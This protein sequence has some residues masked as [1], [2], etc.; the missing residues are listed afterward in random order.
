MSNTSVNN[1]R[2]VKNSIALYFRMLLVIVVTLYTSRMVLHTLG[3]ED[4]GIYNVV[5]GVVVMLG[6]LNSS[7]SGA[8]SRFITFALGKENLDEVGKTFSTFLFIHVLLAVL[9]LV[10]AETFGLWFVHNKLV[11]PAERMTAA[12]WVYH[13]SVLAAVVSI[14][15]VPYNSLII[16]HERMSAFA[17][18]SLIEVILKL[19][20]V[21]LLIYLP[22]DKLAIYA[23]LVLLVQVFIR[24]I[25]NSY[26]IRHFVESKEKPRYYPMQFKS[27]ILYASWTLNG[28]IAVIGY[29]QGLNILLN[30]FFGPSVNA[31]RGVAVQVD[32]AIKQF[33]A[34]F[35][36]AVSPQI[37]KSYASEDLNHM[38]QLIIAL[39]KY[40]VYLVLLIVFPLY[41]CINPILHIW[42][43][44]V[45]EHTANFIRIMLLIAVIEPLRGAITSGIHATGDIKKF[46]IWEG[47]IL[48]SV[49]PVAYILLKLYHI[50]PEA[51][52]CV[53]LIIAL[54]TQGVRV[55]IVLPKIKM[56]R[57]LYIKKVLLPLVLPF[58]CAAIPAYCFILSPNVTLITLCTCILISI[59]YIALIIYSIGINTDERKKIH[60]TIIKIISRH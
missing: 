21:Y 3:V 28:N 51:V 32:S 7:L 42:L 25:Y 20:I 53:Y 9:I 31:A 60:Q 6:F 58:L 18:I 43:G 38:H 52:F 40:G 29:T 19:L 14:L 16:A 44:D 47:S 30:L 10:L 46:Q 12:L 23:V 39:S 54:I 27:I 36:T 41:I 37:I 24:F 57:L 35:Q 59:L 33:V 1:K 55:F 5:G 22:I 45:P 13:A 50:T 17:Y 8:G 2:I 49:V 48:L 56:A 15:S 11:M 26:C 4:Y 34:G